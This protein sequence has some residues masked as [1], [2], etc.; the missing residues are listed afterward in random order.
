MP[1]TLQFRNTSRLRTE[2]VEG[3][4][5]EEIAELVKVKVFEQLR[6]MGMA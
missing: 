1:S 3:K 2:A 6:A 4:T 5:D